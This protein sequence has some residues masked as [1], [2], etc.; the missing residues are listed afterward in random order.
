MRANGG[1]CLRLFFVAI[2][3]ALAVIQGEELSPGT[4][5]QQDVARGAAE[6]DESEEAAGQQ[7]SGPLYTAHR[8][9]SY[10]DKYPPAVNVTARS[11]YFPPGAD[12]CKA[13]R[14]CGG[15]QTN[16]CRKARKRCQRMAVMGAG[17]NVRL[18]VAGKDAIVVSYGP[19]GIPDILLQ[20]HLGMISNPPAGGRRH[21][22]PGEDSRDQRGL[23]TLFSSFNIG[24]SGDPYS[25]SFYGATIITGRPGGCLCIRLV[26]SL[27]TVGICCRSYRFPPPQ[28][29]LEPNTP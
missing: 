26:P 6:A 11:N 17:N 13:A 28:A 5:P 20:G 12:L 3:L 29:I 7:R 15:K 16:K 9:L 14:L 25:T 21:L 19:D 18:Q 1:S 22:S 23:Q 2:I 4:D 8:S 24:S 27:V 10:K